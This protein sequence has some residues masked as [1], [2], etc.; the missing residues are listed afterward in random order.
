MASGCGRDTPSPLRPA[1]ATDPDEAL[2]DEVVDRIAGT[3]ARS[4]R[5]PELTGMHAA[6]LA[7]L[8]AEAPVATAAPRAQLRRA[9]RELRDYLED[10]AMRADSGPLARL[11]A[12][13]SASVAQHLA[14]LTPEAP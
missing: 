9:E 1:A 2:V 7:A 6:H 4:G 8:D 11:L 3:A 13:M 14:A 10:A 5:V 12:S